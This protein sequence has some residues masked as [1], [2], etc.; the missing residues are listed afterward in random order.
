VVRDVTAEAEL[1]ERERELTERY[2]RLLS[3]VGRVLHPFSSTLLMVQHTLTPLGRAL[4]SDPFEEGRAPTL[5]EADAALVRPVARLVRSLDKL[6]TLADGERRLQALPS[7][8]WNELSSLQELLREYRDTIPIEFRT[9]ALREAAHKV[10]ESCDAIQKS[11]L[12]QEPVRQVRRSAEA[13]ERLTCHIDLHLARTA[14]LQ[15]DHQIHALRDF[16]TAGVREEEP[17]SVCRLSDLVSEAIQRLAGFARNRAVEIR[18]RELYP[19]VLVRVAERDVVR[20][21]ANLLH[22]AIKYSWHPTPERPRWVT[23][24]CTVA[25][26][27]VAVAFRNYGVPIAREEIEQELIFQVGY[28][29]RLSQDRGRMGTG[30]GLADA[31]AVARSHAGEVIVESRP[32]HADVQGDGQTAPFLTTATLILPLHGR[33]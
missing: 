7:D 18:Y 22:N 21:L 29:G 28:R 16:V 11:V 12:A 5:E 31:R 3:D 27:R 30:I 8:K 19:R 15:M 9:S 33:E 6:L 14:V 2:N 1:R 20:A 17:R 10:A 23:V 32:A 4:R 25:K 13:L 24:E 26:G